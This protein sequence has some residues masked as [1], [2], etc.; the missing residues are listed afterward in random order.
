FRL[1]IAPRQRAGPGRVTAAEIGAAHHT[2]LELVSL[3]RVGS[4]PELQAEAE[5]LKAEAV[6]SGEEIEVLD[7]AAVADFWQSKL[8]RQLLARR[9]HLHR[10]VPFTARFSPEDLQHLNLVRDAAQLGDEFLVV[11]GYVDLAVI[12]PK[13]IWLVDFKT[14]VVR[15]PELDAKVADFERQL[16][17]YGLALRRIYNRPVT[18]SWLHFLAP[19]KTVPV[20][21]SE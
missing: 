12:L 15:G 6:L 8:G 17:L 10:E 18:A 1:D 4:L 3:E 19:K 13:E 11:Q 2:F 21:K 16:K 9:A 5:R 7:L 20:G 14:D